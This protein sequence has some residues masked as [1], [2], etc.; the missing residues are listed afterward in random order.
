MPS[1]QIAVAALLILFTTLET[2]A[3]RGGFN[4][5]DHLLIRVAHQY[6]DGRAEEQYEGSPFLSDK[7]ASG[8]V[9]TGKETFKAVSMRYNVYDDV[10]EFE[11]KGQIYLLDPEP[12]IG[13]IELGTDVLVVRKFD[14]AKRE[15]GYLMLVEEGKLKLFARKVVNYRKAVPLQSIPAKYSRQPDV[16]YVQL[17]DHGLSKVGSVKGLIAELPDKQQ[18]MLQFV[19]AEKISAKDLNDL[20]KLIRFYNSL[21]LE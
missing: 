16:F 5:E 9:S 17:A 3:Q 11:H 4:I 15:T 18:E 21:S 10:I 20:V 8:N 7:F 2:W 19:K 1:R 12:R 6:R 14:A 13:R